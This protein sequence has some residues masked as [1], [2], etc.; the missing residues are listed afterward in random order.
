MSRKTQETHEDASSAE[1]V[2]RAVEGVSIASRRA[3]KTD[4]LAARVADDMVERLHC[5]ACTGC[6]V[7]YRTVLSRERGW[8]DTRYEFDVPA[9]VTEQMQ[10][11]SYVTAHTI[12]GGHVV[13]CR[14]AGGKL[15]LE[16]AGIQIEAVVVEVRRR[17]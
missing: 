6:G 13:S 9:R 17:P 3:G 15:R 5:A 8:S 7:V 2:Q 1:D 11:G 10:P 16:L 14:I 12:G 4:Q